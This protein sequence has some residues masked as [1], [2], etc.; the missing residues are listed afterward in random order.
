VAAKRHE[1]LAQSV[2]LYILES[3]ESNRLVGEKLAEAGQRIQ[4][5]AIIAERNQVRPG[6]MQQGMTDMR[7]GMAEMQRGMVEMQ[8]SMRDSFN[9]LAHIAENP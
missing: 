8:R 3:R 4:A 7:L 9:R 1:A 6:E 5:L 2:E